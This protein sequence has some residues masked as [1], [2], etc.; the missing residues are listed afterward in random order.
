MD[1]SSLLPQSRQAEGQREVSV[2][3]RG[4]QVR[5][6]GIGLALFRFRDQL[7][8]SPALLGNPRMNQ[9][10]QIQEP[11]G[12]LETVHFVLS[13]GLACRIATV[14]F[15]CCCLCVVTPLSVYPVA[16]ASCA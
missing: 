9:R 2:G 4:P 14:P 10:A 3:A 7:M 15:H 1:L 13:Q 8:L 6:H 11:V 5:G 16:S 12:A